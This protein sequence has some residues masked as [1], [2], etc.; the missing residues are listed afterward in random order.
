[1]ILPSEMRM[2]AVN[3][4]RREE[5]GRNVEA[6]RQ[7]AILSRNSATCLLVP[8][9]RHQQRH[10]VGDSFQGP[11]YQAAL[12][13]KSACPWPDDLECKRVAQRV[14]YVGKSRE[15]AGASLR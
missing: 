12:L 2:R 1:M 6:G 10:R 8:M 9:H 5:S 3:E 7:A 13:M 15:H 11:H 4:R 14:R